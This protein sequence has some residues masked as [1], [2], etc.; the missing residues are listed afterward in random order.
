MKVKM[1]YTCGVSEKTRQLMRSA[2]KEAAIYHGLAD[3]DHLVYVV[4]QRSVGKARKHG[5]IING[6]YININ[7]KSSMIRIRITSRNQMART[8]FHE[9]AHLRHFLKKELYTLQDIGT[10]FKGKEYPT[11]KNARRDLTYEDYLLLP[12]EIDA[13]NHESIMYEK[14]I[15]R[16][17]LPVIFNRILNTIQGFLK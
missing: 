13:R 4:F 8:L 9:F 12:D 5:N 7:E 11:I 3:D 16:G 10:F 14:W 17:S 1:V 2:I 6:T 15:S